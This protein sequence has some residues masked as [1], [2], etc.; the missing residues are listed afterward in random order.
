LIEYSNGD[1][2]KVNSSSIAKKQRRL[3]PF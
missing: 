1:I 2:E 3:F